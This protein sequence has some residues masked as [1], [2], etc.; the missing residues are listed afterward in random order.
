MSSESMAELVIPGSEGGTIGRVPLSRRIADRIEGMVASGEFAMGARL[1]AQRELATQLGVSRAVLREAIS[2]LEASGLLRTEAGSGTFVIAR[3]AV[4]VPR[5]ASKEFLPAGSYGK[6]DIC[7]FRFV[8]EPACARLAAM[9]I[10]DEDF[11]RLDAN[12]L[13]FKDQVRLGN[14]Q[15]S[16]LI[17]EAFHH[18]IIEIAAVPLFI[19]LH[20]S[21]RQMLIE[22]VTMPLNTHSRGW[23]PV[24]EHER[25]LEA[26]RR[27]DPDESF[28]YLKSH[29]TRSSERLGFVLADDV[30]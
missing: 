25:I 27:R 14:F 15:Q 20:L 12:L 3:G 7:R 22:T 19:D 13:A 8:F 2:T 18:L 24:V 5:S 9:R 4:S 16:A 1:P 30:L 23:E 11:E 6:L 21:F 29:I 10:S 28:Y 26:L 17:D